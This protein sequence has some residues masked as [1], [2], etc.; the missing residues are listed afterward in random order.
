MSVTSVMFLVGFRW[1]NAAQLYNPYT[2]KRQRSK[3][4][5]FLILKIKCSGFG[6]TV[7]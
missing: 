5:Y 1:D 3:A 7:K 4:H 6:V 2:S